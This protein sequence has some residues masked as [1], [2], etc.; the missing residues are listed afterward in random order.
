M[1]TDDILQAQQNLEAAALEK[2]Y[3]RYAANVERVAEREGFDRTDQVAAMIRGAIPIVAEGLRN[4]LETF[5]AAKGRKPVALKAVE[6]MDLDKL[7]YLGLSRVFREL[8][9][10]GNVTAIVLGIGRHMQ[11]ELEAD[12]IEAKDAKAAKR[13]QA[14]ATGTASERALE[15]R[16]DALA[17]ELDVRLGWDN[18]TRALNGQSVLSVILL[19]LPEVFQLCK[20]TEKGQM[21][22]TVELT[23]EAATRLAEM[24][25]QAAWMRPV[26]QPMLAPPRPWTSL[27]TGCYYD[28]RLSKTVPLVRTYS[29]EHR[30]LLREAI[31][32][33][34]MQEV[35][36]AVNAIQETRFA[37]DTKVLAAIRWC[38]GSKKRPGKSFP[39]AEDSLPKLPDKLN[40][41]EWAALAPET[42]RAMSRKRKTIDNIRK[43]AGTERGGFNGDMETAEM[44]AGHAAFYIPHSLD[45]RG[46]VYAVPHFNHQR[47]DHMKGLFRFADALP[48]GDD[49]GD[50]LMIHLANCGDFEKVSKE[51]FVDRIAWVKANEEAILHAANSPEEAYE[52]WGQADSPFCFLQACF[53]YAAWAASGFSQDFE[54]SIAIA[55]DGSCSGLQHYA[56][57]TRS[58]QEAHH[59]NLTPRDKPGD[60]YKVVA[61]EA[62][63]HLELG[64][65][66]DDENARVCAKVLEQGFGR[67][68]V[69]RNVM[70]YFYGSAKFGMRE[71]H[72]EDT[73]RP[74]ADQVAMGELTEHPYSL[75]TKRTNKE[76]GEETWAQDGGYSCAV[77]MAAYTHQAVITVAHKA[78]EAA[79]WIQKVAALLAHESQS[80]IWRTPTGMPVVQRYSEYTSKAVNLWLYDR[81]VPVPTSTDKTDAEGNTLVRIQLLIREAPTK[82]VDKKRM[83]S[84]SSPNVIHS[85]DGAHLQRSVVFGKANG[86]NHFA[87]I[88]DSFGT[89]AGNMSLFSWAIR[90]AF[91]RTYETYCPLTELDSYARSVLSDADKLPPIPDKGDLDLGLIRDSLYAFA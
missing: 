3:A 54:S 81:G 49:G 6:L 91:V 83:R 84:A 31:K 18:T 61:D 23:P 24:Q 29:G 68:E 88:H 34:S 22:R 32:D 14:L 72:I 87:M 11:V 17:D 12:A 71:Q 40:A 63:P 50:W 27:G 66:R 73:M 48:L 10:G 75:L 20:T 47:S 15:R 39:T 13:Y 33:G 1:L 7:A 37:I 77:V 70:T 65:K 59:V 76:T 5:K 55:A 19:R 42:K 57:I 36:D 9:N 38:E 86:I 85:M 62:K 53:E 46:R 44:L 8:P 35:L 4:W 64:T 26:L 52:F 60:I 43:A 21:H 82:R 67:S 16:H 30:K 25:D 45:F 28:H 80:M 58:P 51:S 78:E 74:L 69:K 90:E 2:G 56:A 79:T 89:H 41:D